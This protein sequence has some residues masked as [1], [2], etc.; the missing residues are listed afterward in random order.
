[1]T[2]ELSMLFV[3]KKNLECSATELFERVCLTSVLAHRLQDYHPPLLH[4]WNNQA[5]AKVVLK[6]KNQSQ[7]EKAHSM[8]GETF[9]G[10]RCLIPVARSSRPEFL[11]KLQTL[12]SLQNLKEE[13]PFVAD[14]EKD[15]V[16][17]YTSPLLKMSLG[18]NAAQTSHAAL[19]WIRA[20]MPDLLFTPQDRSFSE[21]LQAAPKFVF[22]TPSED[23][24]QKR[25]SDK[26]SIVV[27]D[28]G[29]TEVA[30]GSQ[31]VLA[32]QN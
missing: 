31:T 9:Q 15:C 12:Q 8:P 28:A 19:L 13:T 25:L 29:R 24:W 20:N 5:F 23:E 1:M 4:W 32:F 10:V 17:I 18:K 2:K 7:W 14:K 16:Y 11:N 22:A 26:D 30:P 6:A 21:M 3:V 27:Q